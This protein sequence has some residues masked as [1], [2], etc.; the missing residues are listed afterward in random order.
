MTYQIVASTTVSPDGIALFDQKNYHIDYGEQPKK[1]TAG[2]LIRSVDLHQTPLPDDL[3]TIGRAGVGVNNIPLA[4]AAAKGIVV[5]N[6]PGANANGV[7]ELVFAALTI[8]ARPMLAGSKW[9]SNLKGDDIGVQVEK[10]KKAY[11]GTELLGKKLGVIGLGHV[12]GLVANGASSQAFGMHV[13]GY[14]PYIAVDT[15]WHLSHHIK[16]AADL[17]GVLEDSDYVT[18]HVP[19]TSET[20]EMLNA[21]AI[22]MMKP[23]SVLLNFA[24]DDVIDEDAIIAALDRGHLRRYITDFASP[25][26][27][28]HPKVT[29]FPHIGGS[30]TAAET[31]SAKM[32]VQT[33]KNYLETGNIRNSVTFPDTDMQFASPLRLTL[34]HKNVPNMVGKM[35]GVLSNYELNIVNMMNRSQGDYA[36]TMI[37]LDQIDPKRL[38]K[39]AA[40][41]AQIDDVIRVRVLS[42]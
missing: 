28:H 7:K 16:H 40:K 29:V 8:G 24:R 39:I 36:Y 20:K 33:M 11:V 38:Q 34:I 19:L 42:H 4:E 5:F 23:G 26:L 22:A 35:T 10:G 14:D 9:V 37:D 30:T 12:G 41:M 32:V 31:N 18:I 13:V 1:D 27:I 15:A 17:K 3:I 2:L 6:A 21:D 25:K